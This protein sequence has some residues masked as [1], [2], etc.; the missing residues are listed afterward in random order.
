MPPSRLSVTV[1]TSI[2]KDLKAGVTVKTVCRRYHVS[3]QTVYRWRK[4][5]SA[6][7]TSSIE[8]L[9]DLEN[10]NRKLKRKVAELSLDYNTLRIAL[11]TQA[12]TEC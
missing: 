8:R 11:I 7:G 4:K 12:K 5:L 1:L 2:A 9:R 6:E 3:P 10:E